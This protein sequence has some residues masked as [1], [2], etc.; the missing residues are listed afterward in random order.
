MEMIF[1]ED[2]IKPQINGH[3]YYN[4]PPVFNWL[5][6]GCMLIFSSFDEWVIRLPGLVSHLIIAILIYFLGKRYVPTDSAIVASLVYFTSGELLFYGCV[7]AG[8]IDLFFS[9]LV[10][11]QLYFLFRSFEE[12]NTYSWLILS[13]LMLAVGILTKGLPSIA[14]QGLTII[15]WCI[16]D[17]SLRSIQLGKHLLG[18]I[19]CIFVT[20]AY[21]KAYHGSGGNAEVYLINLFNEA[22]QKSGLE[23][24]RSALIKTIFKFP[25]TFLKLC[26]PWILFSFLLFNQTIRKELLANSYVRFSLVVL[27]SNMGLYW[28][29]GSVTSR[30]LYPMIPFIAI[31]LGQ[32]ILR[33]RGG[34]MH[35]YFEKLMLGLIGLSPAMLIGLYFSNQGSLMPGLLF[36]SAIAL[37]FSVLIYFAYRKMIL[38]GTFLAVVIILCI[39]MYSF[40]TYY[41]TRYA[42]EQKQG[43]ISEIP[44]FFRA[45]EGNKIHLLGNPQEF[46]VD[47]SI[48]DLKMV[49]G[50]FIAPMPLSYQLPYYIEK[51]QNAIMEFHQ[52]PRSNTYYLMRKEDMARYSEVFALDLLYEFVDDW[53]RIPL[54]VVKTQ[55]RPS[56]PQY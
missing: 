2:F 11:A 32:I 51:E 12:R 34:K 6:V 56:A 14:F 45:T 35:A 46:S 23:A 27:L 31:V 1:S 29:S 43:L 52:I 55:A 22:S 39:K 19:C 40:W 5:V 37:L 4:K 10:F 7:I 17:R 48:G 30:Y 26:L 53:N 47:V 36:K 9:L 16:A 38:K 44:K 13:Y 42:D 25:S 41:P 15:G 33:S 24:D 8:Q 49:E 20:G 50:N 3:P 54:A 21:F 18:I 28:I